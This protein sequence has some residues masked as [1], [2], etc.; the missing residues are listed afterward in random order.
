MDLSLIPDRLRT[1]LRT[2]QASEVADRRT[3]QV[4]EV[5]DKLDGRIK[6]AVDDHLQGVW[7]D[8]EAAFD[9]LSEKGRLDGIEF[10]RFEKIFKKVHTNAIPRGLR[11]I[12]DCSGVY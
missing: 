3:R 5:A 9:L 7:M 4:A 8:A 6:S 11:L 10:P 1:L 2:L 12:P